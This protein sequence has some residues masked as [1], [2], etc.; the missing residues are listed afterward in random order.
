MRKIV[1]VMLTLILGLS[2]TG[3]FGSKEKEFEGTGL[4]VTLNSSFKET[5]YLGIQMALQTKDHIFTSL[6]ES[7]S[8]LAQYG[9]D[10][11]EEYFNAV[12]SSK[13]YTAELNEQKDE[14]G[15]VQFLYGYYGATVDS[16]DF[17]YMLVVL[18]GE[19]YMYTVNFGC[20]KKNLEKNKEQ[21][22]DWAK[23]I[24]VE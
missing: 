5:E 12:L 19:D 20:F 13:N 4:K 2:L 17:G 16:Q 21:Y 24:V 14:N 10:N 11:L 15:K 8:L 6:R 9:V 7:K 18:E 23:T 22:L 3:C 1:V